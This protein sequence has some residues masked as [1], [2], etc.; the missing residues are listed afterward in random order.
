MAHISPIRQNET[1]AVLIYLGSMG[2]KG[3]VPS[4]PDVDV[5]VCAS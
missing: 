1:Q 3:H 2:S 5:E 4:A